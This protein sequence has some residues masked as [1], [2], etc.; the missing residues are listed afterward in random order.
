V[1]VCV[2][3][4]ACQGLYLRDPTEFYNLGKLIS[5][6]NPMQDAAFDIMVKPRCRL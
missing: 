2:C 1:S 4:C 5:T 3:V 6:A